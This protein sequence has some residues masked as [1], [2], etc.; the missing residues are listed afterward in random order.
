MTGRK[1]SRA[2]YSFTPFIPVDS[3]DLF[4]CFLSA[5]HHYK[6]ANQEDGD[7]YGSGNNSLGNR[8]SS[9]TTEGKYGLASW[10]G[11]TNTS[12][13]FGPVSLNLGNNQQN[14]GRSSSIPFPNPG[15]NSVIISD[16]YLKES[17]NGGIRGTLPLLKWINNNWTYGNQFI[18][19]QENVKYIIIGHDYNDEGMTSFFA[20][21]LERYN[22][23]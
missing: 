17:G 11:V 8:W 2:L 3:K 23:D 19:T 12:P 10:N 6:R 22:Y 18:L 5:T 7:Y 13:T 20:Y 21:R 1:Y 9:L 4:N 16:I 14:S 15:S